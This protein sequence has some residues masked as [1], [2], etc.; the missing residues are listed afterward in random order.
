MS[1]GAIPTAFVVPPINLLLTAM[2]GLLW[3]R[4]SRISSVLLATGIGGLLLLSLPAVSTLLLVTLEA[5]L[6][7]SPGLDNPPQAIIILSGDVARD[8]GVLNVGA[9]TLERE[10]TGA[11]LHRRTGLPILVTGGTLD[12]GSQ[13][14]GNLMARTLA[15]DFQTP[16]RW[17]ECKAQDTEEN[18]RFSAEI[19]RRDGIRSAY[20]VTHAWHMKRSVL[21]FQGTGIVI[22]AA[23]VR[24]DNMPTPLLGDFVPS[25]KAWLESY[26]ALH[27][28]IGY[29]VARIF[30]HRSDL[31]TIL[32]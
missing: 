7:T 31:P 19:L 11:A 27:E 9:L 21:D 32:Q 10:R 1:L 26:Y 28:W 20:L 13:T 18:A 6:P 25:T 22:T 16:V 5:D 2:A 3:N 29:I 24:M 17:I 15:A 23:P 8:A 12:G 30:R 14:L 4:R